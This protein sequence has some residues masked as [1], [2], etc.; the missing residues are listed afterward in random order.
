MATPY[1]FVA[2]QL[3][4]HL[5]GARVEPCIDSDEPRRDRTA[6]LYRSGNDGEFGDDYATLKL[7]YP[8]G[9][10]FYYPLQ[11]TQPGQRPLIVCIAP[12]FDYI[13]RF[14]RPD[15][16]IRDYLAHYAYWRIE[17]GVNPETTDFWI[18]MLRL[19]GDASQYLILPTGKLKLLLR[20]AYDPEKFSLLLAKSGLCFAAQP[21]STANRLAVLKN[22]SLLDTVENKDLKMDSYLNNWSQLSAHA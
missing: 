11:L 2:N 6:R 4:T 8:G 18:L 17:A 9:Y 12:G 14:T 1:E 21:L 16:E 7:Q 15:A 3:R 19:K 20:K 13:Q 10:P 22:P 5:P